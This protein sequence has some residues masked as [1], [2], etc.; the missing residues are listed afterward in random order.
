M[1]AYVKAMDSSPPPAPASAC[2]TLSL[3]CAA[4]LDGTLCVDSASFSCVVFC[5]DAMFLFSPLLVPS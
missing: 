5:A 2:A 3:C 1:G 4:E